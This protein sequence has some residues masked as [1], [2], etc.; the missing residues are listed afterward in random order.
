[1][2]RHYILFHLKE[3][4]EELERTANEIANDPDYSECDLCTDPLN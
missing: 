1:M 3:A 2:L 4:Q